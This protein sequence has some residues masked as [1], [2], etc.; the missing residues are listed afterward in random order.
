MTIPKMCRLAEQHLDAPDQLCLKAEADIAEEAR[1]KA[2]WIER[3]DYWERLA[4][5]AAKQRR[6]RT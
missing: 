4:A 1:R 3:A 5:K 6:P 2:L